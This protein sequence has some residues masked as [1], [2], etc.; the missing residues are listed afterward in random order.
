M[1][2][3][4][5]SFAASGKGLERFFKTGSM[6]GIRPAH[7]PKLRIVLAR[8]DAAKAPDDLRLPGLRLH[9]LTG[10]RSGTWSVR[11]SGNWRV[12]FA[13]EDRDVEA[14]DYEDYH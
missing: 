9:Q 7:A 8:L 6:A 13:F 2:T 11:I 5:E 12:T 4:H 14:V 1:V 10:G 3:V